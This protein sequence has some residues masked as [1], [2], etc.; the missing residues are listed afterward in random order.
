M[1]WCYVCVSMCELERF[2]HAM[3]MGGLIR[4]HVMGVYFI[5]YTSRGRCLVEGVGGGAW[6]H[7]FHLTMLSCLY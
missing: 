3:Q 7:L 5:E 2:L 1:C 4:S 6:L